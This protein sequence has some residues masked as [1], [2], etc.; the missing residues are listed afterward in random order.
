MANHLAKDDATIEL[1]DPDGLIPDPVGYDQ[2]VYD[3]LADKMECLIA[4]RLETIIQKA[5]NP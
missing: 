2:L 5:G 1:L 4:Q 3:A